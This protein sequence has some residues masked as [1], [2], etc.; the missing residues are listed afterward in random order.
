ME[1]VIQM[2][3][4]TQGGKSIHLFISLL[5]TLNI[6][7]HFFCWF[8]C[9]VVVEGTLHMQGFRCMTLLCQCEFISSALV[10]CSWAADK[11]QTI[12][13]N[14][15]SELCV[16]LITKKCYYSYFE[17]SDHKSQILYIYT[18]LFR[19][20]FLFLGNILKSFIKCYIRIPLIRHPWDQTGVGLWR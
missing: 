10:R 16:F 18:C 11:L 7:L 13:P 19:M 6:V 8:W 9:W 5:C 12:H 4:L 14:S 17:C 15:N 3:V 20:M 1:F 2:C